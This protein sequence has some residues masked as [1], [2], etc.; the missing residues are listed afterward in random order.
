MR[1]TPKDLLPIIVLKF[2]DKLSS[3]VSRL[4]PQL[5]K[6]YI[7]IPALDKDNKNVYN[8][9]AFEIS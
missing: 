1:G 5:Y 4:D 3:E 7:K 9:S 6:I 2:S 8:Y